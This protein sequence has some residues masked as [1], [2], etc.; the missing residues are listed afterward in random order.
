MEE[1]LIESLLAEAADVATAAG[2]SAAQQEGLDVVG[3]LV[4]VVGL[5]LLVLEQPVRLHASD[6]AHYLLPPAST[7]M[8]VQA[9]APHATLIQFQ[10]LSARQ[11]YTLPDLNPLEQVLVEVLEEDLGECII[12]DVFGVQLVPALRDHAFLLDGDG[13]DEDEGL[14][15][16]DGLQQIG[17]HSDDNQQVHLVIT[18][19]LLG[20]LPHLLP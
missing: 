3:S 19:Y 11:V 15:V 7:R 20:R 12:V 16:V 10:R 17:P 1:L 5:V 2:V 13:C 8:L 4:V 6:L 18:Q 9:T 14:G